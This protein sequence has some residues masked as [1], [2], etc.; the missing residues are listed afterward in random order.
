M[1]DY[2]TVSFFPSDFQSILCTQGCSLLPII[3][4][5]GRDILKVSLRRTCGRSRTLDSDPRFLV[6]LSQSDSHNGEVRKTPENTGK[7]FFDFFEHGE[8]LTEL[9]FWSNP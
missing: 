6:S 2:D 5:S 7:P 9:T 3:I 8:Y 4:P 1:T